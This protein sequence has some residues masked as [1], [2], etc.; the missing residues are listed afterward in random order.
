MKIIRNED[1]VGKHGSDKDKVRSMNI[2][3]EELAER[4]FADNGASCDHIARGLDTRTG[5][6]VEAENSQEI[7]GGT[8]TYPR[9]SLRHR[10]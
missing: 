4:Y 9:A 8:S 2:R 5:R 1:D 6:V 10:R 7:T 3:P